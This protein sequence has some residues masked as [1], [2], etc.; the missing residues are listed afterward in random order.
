[1]RFYSVRVLCSTDESREYYKIN[2]DENAKTCPLDFLTA[3]PIRL[4]VDHLTSYFPHE[5]IRATHV[6][7][8]N[9]DTMMLAMT[10]DRFD[11]MV[12]NGD[13]QTTEQNKIAK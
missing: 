13:Y 5:D 12:M 8:I 9:G 11:A 1:M 3:R 4:N 10:F 2:D 6:Y 7:M